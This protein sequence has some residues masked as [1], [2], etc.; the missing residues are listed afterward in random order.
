M[1]F[2]SP[3]ISVMICTYNQAHFIVRAINSVRAQSYNNYEVVIFD[4]CSNDDTQEVVAKHL[5]SID[6]P[7]VLYF[8]NPHNLGIL[9]NYH[10]A[11][12]HTSGELVVNLDGDD[13][14]V[15]PDFFRDAVSAFAIDED[16]ILVFADYCE[17]SQASKNRV[18]IV[19]TRLSSLISD[20]SFYQAFSRNQITWNHNAII[21]KRN[22]A[23]E[24][25][26]YWHN[27]VPRN[28]WESFLRLIAGHKVAYLPSVVAAWV[29]H[30]NNET[31]RSDIN[32]Y[33][34]NYALLRG[35]AAHASQFF[36][37]EF[38]DQW[39]KQMIWMK[40]KSSVAG[41]LINRDFR[42]LIAFLRA[43]LSVDKSLPLRVSTNPGLLLRALISINPKLYHLFKT[44]YR[45]LK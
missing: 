29:Q 10:Q 17:Y 7:R 8:K 45:K 34:N 37:K 32:K 43:I 33:M 39:H 2:E 21:Y 15:N 44:A 14:F 36:D 42:G 18:D 9:R 35:L 5:E 13:F 38:V 11:L 22:P 16:I 4:D 20:R 28:D 6:D 40:T 1:T 12:S 27:S 24:L 41:Y 31:R 19:N 26:F 3:K 25:G 30:S 23:I